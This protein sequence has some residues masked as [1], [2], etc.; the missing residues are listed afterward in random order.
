MVRI[1]FIAGGRSVSFVTPHVGL[2]NRLIPIGCILTLA[3][4]L[5]YSPRMFW[6]PDNVVGRATFGDLFESTNLPFELVEGREARTMRAILFRNLARISS[7]PKRMGL[8]LI[9][10]LVSSQYDKRLE[11]LSGKSKVELIDQGVTDLLSFRKIIIFSNGLI[12][13]GCDL[14]WLKPAPQ[15]TFKIVELKNRF[16]PNTIGVHIRGTDS[17]YRPRIERMAARMRAEIELDP[18]VK[19]F[20]ASDGDETGEA[21]LARFKD[22]FIKPKKGATRSTLQGQQ[23]AV[24]D[25][26]GLAGTSRIIGAQYSS[27]PL[28]ASLIGN[29]PFC[30]IASS[31]STN[32][33][34]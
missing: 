28:L 20:F 23:D 7:P 24:V 21:L 6:A 18:D 17:P 5:N 15:L 31:A 11:L 1:P 9:G 30:K 26:F 10:S 4:E 8:R 34:N 29:T 3:A 12:R 32:G 22:R 2:G 14:S 19:F 25:L 27:F 13:Y 16:A 33:E